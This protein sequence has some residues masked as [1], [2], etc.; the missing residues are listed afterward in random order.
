MRCLRF[1]LIFS[2]SISYDPRVAEQDN[3]SSPFFIRFFFFDPRSPR[4]S[5]FSTAGRK[6][7]LGA[8]YALLALGVPAGS[9]L[10]AAVRARHVFNDSYKSENDFTSFLFASPFVSFCFRRPK[11]R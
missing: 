11:K 10:E 1:I 7:A 8:G 6:V 2:F 3:S 5:A 4:S 9:L